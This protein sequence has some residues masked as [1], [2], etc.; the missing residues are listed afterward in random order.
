MGLQSL[1]AKPVRMEGWIIAH[2]YITALAILGLV[3]VVVMLLCGLFW[4]EPKDWEADDAWIN[5][6]WE[7]LVSR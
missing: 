4:D 5:L 6:Y 1:N 7:F 2:P 3:S